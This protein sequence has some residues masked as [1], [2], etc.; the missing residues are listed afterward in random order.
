[1]KRVG[2]L[3]FAI[4]ASAAGV[5][6]AAEG[7][8]AEAEKE[9]R[10]LEVKLQTLDFLLVPEKE[11]PLMM[12]KVHVAAANGKLDIL[13]FNVRAAVE[14][15]GYAE[16]PADVEVQGS[17]RALMSFVG[18]ALQMRA[19]LSLADMVVA[20]QG[21]DAVRARFT[22]LMFSDRSPAPAAVP[23]PLESVRERFSRKV[24]LVESITRER[25]GHPLWPLAAF[26]GSPVVLTEARLGPPAFE[27]RGWRAPNGPSLRAAFERVGATDVDVEV[28]RE[29]GC[30]SFVVRGRVMRPSREEDFTPDRGSLFGPVRNV[31]G[32]EDRA[33]PPPIADNGSAPRSLTL[34][35]GTRFSFELMRSAGKASPDLLSSA[36]MA[37][38]DVVH[39]VLADR[40][41]TFYGYSV[42][43]VPLE[44]DDRVR[45]L[46]GPL[47]REARRKLELDFGRLMGDP[48]AIEYPPPQVVRPDEPL[49]LELM[50]N[51]ATGEKLYDV[52]RVR[53]VSSAAPE[54]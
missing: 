10:A 54:R 26:D 24:R 23:E 8:G 12:K 51:P 18:S 48:L 14:R 45:V 44:N 22:A 15:E 49:L 37:G 17:F 41:R 7:P 40:K 6:R 30:E 9:R 31:C 43:A 27:I 3:L 36:V 20:P 16:Y 19:L 32:D 11:M 42:K 2:L 47:T 33:G 34:D 1:M 53:R 5:A 50:M 38:K 46:V 39:R 29:G 13:K 25:R 35:D 52:I 28:K 21:D 4:L